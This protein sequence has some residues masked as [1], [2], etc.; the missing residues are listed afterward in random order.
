[1]RTHF[2]IAAIVAAGVGCGS[3]NGG[4]TVPV[5]PS[6]VGDGAGGSG[7]GTAGGPGGGGA[8]SGGGGSGGVA[9]GGGGSGS[10]GSGGSGGG[11]SGGSGGGGGGS[12]GIGGGG[13]G[14]S[15]GGAACDLAAPTPLVTG[16]A[17]MTSI[18]ADG[19]FVYYVSDEGANGVVVYRVAISGGA[20]AALATFPQ[21]AWSDVAVDGNN[22]YFLESGTATPGVHIVSKAA[23][24]DRFVATG[25]ICGIPRPLRL[26][27]F[28]GDLFWT[29][30]DLTTV[31]C[32]GGIE[33]DHLPVGGNAPVRFTAADETGI[34]GILVDAAHVF[35]GDPRGTMRSSWDGT[36]GDRMDPRSAGIL[37]SDGNTL[38]FTAAHDV[39]AVTAP[40]VDHVAYEDPLEDVQGLAADSAHVWIAAS[41]LLRLDVATGATTAISDAP[42]AGRVAVDARYAYY[43]D[44]AHEILKACR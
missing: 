40:F 25:K 32:D 24:G 42:A 43:F 21:G 29:Q 8:G 7:G 23:G 6:S 34:G 37:A 4:A 36:M 33:I 19:S 20:P 41:H 22:V 10:G 17:S 26:A 14:G 35:W 9:G 18:A 3:G 38:Y 2:A 39:W 27:T 13:G 30:R 1:M 16:V 28:G 5:G 31:D 11:G 15:G 44:T 12:G